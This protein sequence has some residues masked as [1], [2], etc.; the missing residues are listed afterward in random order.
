MNPFITIQ[1]ISKANKAKN[2]A[3]TDWGKEYWSKVIRDLQKT[4]N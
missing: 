1:R 2:A 3:N 4:L